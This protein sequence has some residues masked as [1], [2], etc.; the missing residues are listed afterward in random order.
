[1]LVECVDFVRR[2]YKTAWLLFS[3][4]GKMCEIYGRT[5]SIAS[6]VGGLGRTLCGLFGFMFHLFHF[7]GQ[8]M[9]KRQ[10]FPLAVSFC[11]CFF[12][13]E[14]PVAASLL[15]VTITGLVA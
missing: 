8:K 12:F 7:F 5:Q 11:F 6:A 10:Q 4:M 13:L 1:M 14:K 9:N 15:A 2:S 3:K